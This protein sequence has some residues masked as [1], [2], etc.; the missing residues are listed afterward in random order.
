MVGNNYDQSRGKSFS[1]YILIFMLLLYNIFF[2]Q[3]VWIEAI[4]STSSRLIFAAIWVETS[5]KMRGFL[6]SNQAKKNSY[7]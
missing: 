1:V 6:A 5:V 4:P 3:K 2:N 7:E